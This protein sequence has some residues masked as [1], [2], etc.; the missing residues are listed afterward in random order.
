[1]LEILEMPTYISTHAGSLVL[2]KFHVPASAARKSDALGG[3][4]A[5]RYIGG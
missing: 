5:I 3:I 4:G 2:S 1:M